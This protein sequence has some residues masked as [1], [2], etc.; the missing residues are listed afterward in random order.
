[1]ITSS[2]VTSKWGFV[3]FSSQTETVMDSVYHWKCNAVNPTLCLSQGWSSRSWQLW[4]PLGLSGVSLGS[5][6]GSGKL[7]ALPCRENCSD[8]NGFSSLNR[9]LAG[10]RQRISQQTHEGWRESWGLFCDTQCSPFCAPDPSFLRCESEVGVNSNPAGG[11]AQLPAW[12]LRPSTPLC[13]RAPLDKSPR[14]GPRQTADT[15]CKTP[16]VTVTEQT[17]N[18]STHRQ[19]ETSRLR[20]M[21]LL[22]LFV[23]IGSQRLSVL[24]LVGS[25]EARRESVVF[26]IEVLL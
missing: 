22:P 14:R 3:T 26:L 11:S 5:R 16:E 20:V 23:G 9:R 25:E 12:H 15:P 1:M 13:Y 17:Q 24:F 18:K 8:E 7:C 2:S 4:L 10:M 19:W 6:L 21:T